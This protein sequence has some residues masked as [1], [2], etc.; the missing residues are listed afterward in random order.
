MH[1]ATLVKTSSWIARSRDSEKYKMS[2]IKIG[3]KVEK[4]SLVRGS[5]GETSMLANFA[6]K[7]QYVSKLK[8]F[9]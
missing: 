3:K 5:E 6:K 2:K 1:R 7:I 4:K 9:S 8:N